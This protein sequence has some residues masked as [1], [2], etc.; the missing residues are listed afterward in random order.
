MKNIDKEIAEIEQEINAY[1][2]ELGVL[3]DE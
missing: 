1:L 2:K 3:K